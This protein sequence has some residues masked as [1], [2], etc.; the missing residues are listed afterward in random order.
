MGGTVTYADVEIDA[1]D[2]V[3]AYR[4]AMERANA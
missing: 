1:D 4:R 3:A 2:E